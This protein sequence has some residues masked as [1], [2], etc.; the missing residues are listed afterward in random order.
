MQKFNIKSYSELNNILSE[1][2]LLKKTNSN[3]YKVND[4]IFNKIDTEEK[5]IY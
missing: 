5:H 2:N 4:D 3:R 1:M